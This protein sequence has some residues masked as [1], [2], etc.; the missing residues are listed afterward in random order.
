MLYDGPWSNRIVAFEPST[1]MAFEQYIASS[2]QHGG[3]CDEQTARLPALWA[4]LEDAGQARTKAANR[5]D[6]ALGVHVGGVIQAIALYS[7]CGTASNKHIMNL[8]VG[9]AQDYRRK[10]MGTALLMRCAAIAR[11]AGLRYLTCED[12][13]VDALPFTRLASAELICNGGGC[14]AWI[15]LGPLPQA[16]VSAVMAGIRQG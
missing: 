12:V 3:R 7:L 4:E 9:V 10:G 16:T 15:E 13:E 6:G 5:A 14:Q 2:R 1:S 11:Q 8:F